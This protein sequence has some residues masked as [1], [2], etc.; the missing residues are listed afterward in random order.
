MA[1]YYEVKVVK[2]DREGKDRGTKI[3][4]MFPWKSGEGF[5]IVF[6]ALPI[7]KLNDRGELEVV[8]MVSRPWK[9]DEFGN[10]AP[11]QQAPAAPAPSVELDDEIPF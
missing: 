1:D 5:N 7:P 6:D 8:C 9:E 10:R 2:K 11:I 4:A 3:G